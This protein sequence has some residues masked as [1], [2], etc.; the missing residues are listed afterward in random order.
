MYLGQEILV[1]LENTNSV[2]HKLYTLC[3]AHG[4]NCKCDR[5][6]CKYRESQT[7]SLLQS[8]WPSTYVT[9]TFVLFCSMQEGEGSG[10]RKAE[11][12][13]DGATKKAK[14][15]VISDEEEDE[16]EEEEEDDE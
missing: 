13:S 7:E 10:K 1:L 6:S 14:K 4:L 2:V 5:T 11:D 3:S 16:D 12:D 15:Y 9:A 8:A